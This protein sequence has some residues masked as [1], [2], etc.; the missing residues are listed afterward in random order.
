MQS[1]IRLFK[2]VPVKDASKVAA[3]DDQASILEKTMP[4]GF[5]IAPQVIAN[6]SPAEIDDIIAFSKEETGPSGS[7]MNNSFHKS[8]KKVKDAPICQLVVEQFVHYITTYG[9]EQLGIYSKDTVFIP[10]EELD[11]PGLDDGFSFVVIKGYTRDEIMGKLMSL[12]ASGIAMKEGTVKDVVNVAI[13][14]G[15]DD[16][17]LSQVKNKEARAMLYDYLDKIPSDPVEFLRFV[18]YKATNTTLLIKSDVLINAIK[19]TSL[20]ITASSARTHRKA[21]VASR[22]IAKPLAN[23]QIVKYFKKY[24]DE[25]GFKRLSEIFNRFKPLFLAFKTNA[26]LKNYINQIAKLSKRY[27]VPMPEDYLNNVTANLRKGIAIDPPEL[28]L[29]LDK[30]NVFRKARLAYALKFRAEEPSS[31]MYKIRNGSAFSTGFNFPDASAVDPVLDIVIESIVKGLKPVNGKKIYIPGNI[32]YAVPATEKQFTG[33]I[34]SGSFIDV[35]GSMIAGIHWKNLEHNR[36]DLDLSMMNA[37]TKM[38]W[39]G[40]YRDRDASASI[41]FSGDMTDAPGE[42]ASE[43]FYIKRQASNH[44]ILSVN[45]FTHCGESVPFSIFVT[46]SGTLRELP[47]N[48][49]VDPSSVVCKAMTKMNRPQEVIGLIATGKDGARFY[50]SEAQIG[51]SRTSWHADYENHA[52]DYLVSFFTNP[53]S[54]N[55]VLL[56]AGAIIVSNPEDRGKCDLD[57]SPETIAK[58]TFVKLLASPASIFNEK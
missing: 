4:H 58:E 25:I 12:L 49:M 10:K 44:F 22:S 35:A 50:F 26:T 55:D 53:I 36:I 48:Y 41:L 38:G 16:G 6:Y 45:N 33:D 42:G 28:Q 47:R 40:L 54:L 11:V 34:P 32:I 52:L 5:I 1:T 2:G 13:Y 30:V 9:Y 14:L 15:F 57:L 7:Q 39:D 29:R 27:H 21:I 3:I 8:W 43:M 19:G 51:N 24:D 18:I 20:A 56:K 46:T 31:I 37:A 23:I 17:Q